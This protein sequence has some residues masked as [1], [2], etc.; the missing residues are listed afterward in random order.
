MRLRLSAKVCTLCHSFSV[1]LRKMLA[2][3]MCIQSVADEAAGS[4]GAIRTLSSACPPASLGAEIF[5]A[6]DSVCMGHFHME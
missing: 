1:N 4:L 5:A 6:T 2:N 3:A